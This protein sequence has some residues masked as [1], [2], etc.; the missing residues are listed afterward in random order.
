[1]RQVCNVHPARPDK[2]TFLH[3]AWLSKSPTDTMSG[4]LWDT[5]SGIFTTLDAQG[6]RSEAWLSLRFALI[7]GSKFSWIH[8]GHLAMD[9]PF[10][11]SSE[12]NITMVNSGQV[13][14]QPTPEFSPIVRHPG[15]RFFCI[16]TEDGAF[17]ILDLGRKRFLRNR[18]VHCHLYRLDGGVP[19]RSSVSIWALDTNRS[20][21][22]ISFV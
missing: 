17:G 21:G 15:A 10:L 22:K 8:D 7:E 13:M 18:V 12:R 11:F 20:L 4:I 3:V 14:L 16:R 9:V 19:P 1:M 6:K 5:I 2:E